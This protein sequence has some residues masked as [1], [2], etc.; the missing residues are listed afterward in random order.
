MITRSKQ[1]GGALP[2]YGSV[3]VGV[4]SNATVPKEAQ[5]L[6][7]SSFFDYFSIKYLHSKWG[8]ML[9]AVPYW[10]VWKPQQ[11]HLQIPETALSHCWL[12]SGARFI[13]QPV[14]ISAANGDSH[15]NAIIID[16]QKQTAE[17][18]EPHGA[19]ESMVFPH[20]LYSQLDVQ[21]DA[22]FKSL[23][24][25]YHSATQVCPFVGPQYVEDFDKD[26]QGYCAA[27][28]LWY[29]DM[30]MSYPD[31]DRT[32]LIEAMTRKAAQLAK[33]R[34]LATYLQRFLSQV[35]GFMYQEFPQYSK[36]FT[37][38]KQLSRS[39]SREFNQFLEHMDSLTK[40]PTALFSLKRRA[41]RRGASTTT[42]SFKDDE[43]LQGDV[44]DD[45]LEDLHLMMRH[46]SRVMYNLSKNQ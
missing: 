19:Q 45:Q 8:H 34:Q 13:F 1:R 37:R 38:Y 41:T 25:T 27:W 23:G 40:S 43:V 17:R 5:E 31:E 2:A 26:V 28:S 42:P 4:K 3:T 36:F 9:C 39:P 18:F 46:L 29:V 24:V 30:R 35:Y 14:E 15:A 20:F 6:N 21:L 7:Q 10:L 32:Q 11:S 16:V 44:G 12:K 22:Y 33:S